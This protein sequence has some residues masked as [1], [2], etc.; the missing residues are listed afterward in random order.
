MKGRTGV[1]TLA[2]LTLLLAAATDLLIV[3]FASAWIC[4]GATSP[5]S[6][7]RLP[8]DD[9][10]CCCAHIIVPVPPITIP[11]QTAQSFLPVTDFRLVSPQLGTVYHPP[12]A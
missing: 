7:T 4:D 3:D 10:F 12:R 5:G 11:S 1:F 2:A 6:S 8:E 9:C